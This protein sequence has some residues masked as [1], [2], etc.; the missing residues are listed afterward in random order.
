MFDKKK[1]DMMEAE[2][3]DSSSSALCL[4]QGDL[5]IVIDDFPGDK[6]QKDSGKKKKDSIESVRNRI[7]EIKSLSKSINPFL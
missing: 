7:E 2:T 5:K 6:S 4:K 1:S 3:T